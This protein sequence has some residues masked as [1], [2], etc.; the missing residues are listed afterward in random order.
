[1][2]G[3]L[4][5]RG[6]FAGEANG[7]TKGGCLGVRGV[8]VGSMVMGWT[9]KCTPSVTACPIITPPPPP[10]KGLFGAGV[11]GAARGGGGGA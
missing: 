6:D 5:G 1:M 8:V 11:F 2:A 7:H 3:E 4:D 10:P 9:G